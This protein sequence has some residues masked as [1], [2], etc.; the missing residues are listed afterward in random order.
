[1]RYLLYCI[2]HSQ[3][4]FKL[5]AIVGVG[6]QPVSVIVTNGLG[7]A[8]SSIADFNLT[9]EFSQTLTYHQVIESFHRH[10]TV[11][12]MRYGCLFE[13]KSQIAE[14]LEERGG[15]YATLLTELEDCVEMGIRILIPN[16]ETPT[17]HLPLRISLFTPHNPDL[18]DSGRTYLAARK[19]HYAHMEQ[20]TGESIAVAQRCRATF[21]GLFVRC[22]VECPPFFPLP[23]ALHS[24]LFSLYFLVPRRSTE[25]FRKAF[26]QLSAKE[27]AKLL[28]SGPWPPYNF[29]QPDQNDARGLIN[30]SVKS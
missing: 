8:L 13:E 24:H 2:F 15:H 21:A 1:M 18:L 4:D 27:S 30:C 28:L 10:C 11:I 5:E 16:S 29:V 9:L 22:K 14:L 6:G 23:S 3:A 25:T 7:A 12:P 19:T 26:R 17:S 20:L